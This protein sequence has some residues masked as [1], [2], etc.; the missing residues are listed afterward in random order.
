[1]NHSVAMLSNAKF[2]VDREFIQMKS[3]NSSSSQSFFL[4]VIIYVTHVIRYY[5]IIQITTVFIVQINFKFT[6]K[7]HTKNTFRLI[8]I[9]LN[10]LCR[11]YTPFFLLRLFSNIAYLYIKYNINNFKKIQNLIQ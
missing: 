3:Q 9:I 4:L 6:Y 2:I 11:K 10:F 8:K 7:Y 5:N 1:M